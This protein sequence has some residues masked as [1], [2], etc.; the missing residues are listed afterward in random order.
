MS[1]YGEPVQ[2]PVDKAAIRQFPIQKELKSITLHT[3]RM[4]DD[5]TFF[6]SNSFYLF[7]LLHNRSAAQ[8]GA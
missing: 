4:L 8:K 3:Y 1:K 7:A 6:R 2:N 5:A